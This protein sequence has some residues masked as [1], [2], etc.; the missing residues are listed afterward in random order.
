VGLNAV[1]DPTCGETFSLDTA[2]PIRDNP[3]P[4]SAGA[5]G[6][7]P[8][9]PSAARA[10]EN[11]AFIPGSGINRIFINQNQTLQALNFVAHVPH[12]RVDFIPMDY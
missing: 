6:R 8:V 12:Q 7:G 11:F 3:H 5:S 4:S 10:P 1:S 2:I 9:R